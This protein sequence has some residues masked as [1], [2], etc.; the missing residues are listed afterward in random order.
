MIKIITQKSKNYELISMQPYLLKVQYSSFPIFFIL[1]YW[2][3]KQIFIQNSI[4]FAL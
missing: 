4:T 2:F 3:F 1:F